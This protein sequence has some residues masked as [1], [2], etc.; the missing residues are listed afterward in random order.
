MRAG[1]TLFKLAFK[2]VT[3]NRACPTLLLL[4][5]AVTQTAVAVVSSGGRQTVHAFIAIVALKPLQ[6][7]VTVALDHSRVKT[8]EPGAVSWQ[9]PCG[10][11]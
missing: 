4:G 2:L 5:T 7:S 11:P 8:P 10:A 6:S 9:K 1:L 3:A